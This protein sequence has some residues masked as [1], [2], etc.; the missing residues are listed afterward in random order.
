MRVLWTLNML[1]WQCIDEKRDDE[2]FIGVE[3]VSWDENFLH[4]F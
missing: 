1:T 2:S 4:G 3:I